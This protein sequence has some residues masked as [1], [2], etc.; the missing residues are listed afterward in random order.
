L[1]RTVESD[2]GDRPRVYL[3]IGEP[4]TGTTFVQQL[5]W[6]SRSTLAAHGVVVPGEGSQ[7]VFRAVQ[8][9]RDIQKRPDNPT[10]PW[11]GEWNRLARAAAAAPRCAVISHELLCAATDR[12]IRRAVTSLAGAEV[13]VVLTVRDMASLLPAEW[14]ESVKHRSTRSWDDWLADVI[15]KESVA[16]DREQFW[17]WRVHDTEQILDRWARHVPR[18]RIHLVTIPPSGSADPDELWR[19]LAGLLRVPVEAVDTRVARANTS[20]GL[21]EIELLR[22]FNG[23]LSPR[24]PDWFYMWNVKEPL[25]HGVLAKRPA[26]ARL[27]LPRERD[28]WAQRWSA[29]AVDHL[30]SA[31]YDVIGDLDELRPRPANTDRPH[32]DDVTDEQILEAA[33]S[34]TAA[35]LVRQHRRTARA[36]RNRVTLGES[37]VSASKSAPIVKRTLDA[38]SERSATVAGLRTWM[39]TR[40]EQSREVA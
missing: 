17:F 18:S 13:H 31:G 15:D 24:V 38:A 33:V 39:R 10:A 36:R 1:T 34:A 22:R 30:A 28:A 21:A 37:L 25:A 11:S 14:Q 7:A 9:L 26:T 5:L 32:P 29:D 16:A 8:D 20:L 27:A 3:H 2:R 23:T 35:L 4:K 19:R 40:L 12:Q 6:A